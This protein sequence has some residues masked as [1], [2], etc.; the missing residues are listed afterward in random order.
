MVAVQWRQ[1]HAWRLAQHGLS[2]RFPA[3]E[4]LRSVTRTGGIQAQVMSAAE[5]AVCTRV[6]G[7]SP[8]AVRTALWQDRTLVKTWAMR[9]TLH[10]LAARELSLDCT[11]KPGPGRQVNSAVALGYTAHREESETTQAWPNLH[12]RVYVGNCPSTGGR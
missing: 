9:G 1:V 11:S 3:Q 12:P 6:E 4:Y 7:L 5:L 8:R 10:L 2:P